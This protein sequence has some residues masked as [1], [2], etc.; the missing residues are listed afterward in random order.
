MNPPVEL[1][2]RLIKGDN[3]FLAAHINPDG[4]A[5]G[6]MLALGEALSALKKNFILYSRDRVPESYKFLPGLE[7]ITNSITHRTTKEYTLIL[8]DC[9][10]PERADI[11]NIS[12]AGSMVIDHHLREKDFGDSPWIVPQASATGILMFYLIRALNVSVTETMASCLYT[13]ISY[14]TGTFRYPNTNTEVFEVV[15][16]LIK[17]GADPSY[18]ADCLYNSWSETRFNL[19]RKAL[20]TMEIHS[21]VAITVVDGK[22]MNDTSSSPED[23]ENFVNFPRMM[24]SINVSVLLKEAEKNFWR[25][26]IRSVKSFNVAK[27]ASEF[28]GGGHKNAAGFKVHGDIKDIKRR[29][30]EY[31]NKDRKRM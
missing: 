28:G 4:D 8:V 19:L 29:L 2:D 17:A 10:V 24:K 16:E 7:R 25:G 13:A 21:D 15:S 23:T 18:I 5:I 30:L 3:F 11:K 26:S 1:T 14:D 31:I 9:N 12:F 20:N 6:S 27:V 22:M